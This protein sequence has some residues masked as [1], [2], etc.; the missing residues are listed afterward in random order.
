[1]L[2]YCSLDCTLEHYVVVAPNKW[3]IM[4]LIIISPLELFSFKLE[5]C[6]AKLML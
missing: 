3:V 5:K 6:N 4:K 2:I 1:M